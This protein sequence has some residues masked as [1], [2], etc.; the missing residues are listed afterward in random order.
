[1][2]EHRL[3]ALLGRYLE[4]GLP[5]NVALM[6][7]LVEAESAAEVESAIEDRVRRA[8]PA[9]RKRLTALLT[10]LRAHPDAWAT[11]RSVMAEAEHDAAGGPAHWAAVFDRL[12]RTRPEASV[13]L[14]A[15]GSPD[16][17]RAAT[18]EV[19]ERL[20]LWGLLGRERRLLDI[21]CGIGRLALALAPE[22]AEVVGLDVSGEMIAEARRRGAGYPNT[23]FVQTDGRDLADMP[24]AHV[25]L[26]LAADV[27]PYLV[28]SAPGLADRHI[29]E[30]A[31]VLRPGGALLI[32]NYSYRGDDGLD[33]A[34]IAAAFGRSGL[35]LEREGTRDFSLW[36]ATA[37][38]GR[39][40]PD[41]F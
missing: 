31:R 14:Y 21:G 5:A 26:V 28:A 39:R 20:R 30:A 38:L 10:L 36:D 23:R 24:S 15:L 12:A 18:A 34:D 4:G 32:L 13:A 35:A 17:L 2:A 11:I 29:E 6:Q 19:V 3:A 22:M 33:R 7:L 27:F 40:R 25:D 16:I 9:G 8:E 37:Y 41:A 1:M